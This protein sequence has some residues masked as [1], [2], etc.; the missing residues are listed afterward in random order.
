MLFR[1]GGIHY[2]VSA[3]NWVGFDSFSYRITDGRGGFSE[4]RATLEVRPNTSPDVYDE[5]LTTKED[6]VSAL[7]Q[8]LLLK[9]DQDPDGDHLFISSVGEASHCQVQLLADGSVLFV[10]E[11]N[12]NDCY[13]GQASFAYTVTFVLV[14]S[15][16]AAIKSIVNTAI[17]L[18]QLRDRKSVV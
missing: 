4:A 12:F 14:K 18:H 16:Q 11:Q 15:A 6:T 9:N 13:P 17:S 7:P 5:V 1:S 3:D 2:W 10:P 8:R